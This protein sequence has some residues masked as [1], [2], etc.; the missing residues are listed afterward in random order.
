MSE[1]CVITWWKLKE[2]FWQ[3]TEK[4]WTMNNTNTT[5][6]AELPHNIEVM[7][8]ILFIFAVGVLGSVIIELLNN[9]LD[10]FVDPLVKLVNKRYAHVQ[11]R[12]RLH[13][14]NGHP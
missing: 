11:S 4:T 6:Q 7:V 1:F 12:N 9:K 2:I 13:T 5:V 8:G 3:C 10:W 14:M